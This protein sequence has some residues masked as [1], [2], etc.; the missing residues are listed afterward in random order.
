MSVFVDTPF[1]R[2][3]ANSIGVGSQTVQA[4]LSNTEGEFLLNTDGQPIKVGGIGVPIAN[5]DGQIITNTDGQVINQS[6]NTIGTPTPLMYVSTPSVYVIIQAK[7]SNTGLIWVGG[8]T[9]EPG[10]GVSLSHTSAPLYVPASDLSQVYII[11]IIGEGVTFTWGSLIDLYARPV[12]VFPSATLGETG[13]YILGA[14]G[15]PILGEG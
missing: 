8:P 13:E 10:A 2:G 12:P 7:P 11:G 6:G 1:R 5:T 4:V 14:D 15:S 9:V 3:I